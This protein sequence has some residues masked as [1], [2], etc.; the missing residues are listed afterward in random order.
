MLDRDRIA[1]E[2]ITRRPRQTNCQQE[3]PYPGDPT[4]IF[5]M[6]YPGLTAHNP[7]KLCAIE[8]P[9]AIAECGEWNA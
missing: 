2:A 3:P 4:V 7:T 9:H 6:R 8:E 1:M 5:S